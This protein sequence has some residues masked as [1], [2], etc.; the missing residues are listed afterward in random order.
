MASQ[1][2]PG[3]SRLSGAVG[4]AAPDP[5]GSA[6]PGTRLW[7]LDNL[8]IVLICGVVVAHLAALYAGG[9]YQY[10]EPVKLIYSLA[11]CW[12]S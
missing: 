6:P 8:R 7:F 2:K 10:R 5:A 4:P 3:P 12:R 1:T 9:W 11:T